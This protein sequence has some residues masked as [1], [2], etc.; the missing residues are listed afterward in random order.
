MAAAGWP[1]PPLVMRALPR[2]LWAWGRSGLRVMA[3]SEG[4]DG[5]VGFAGGS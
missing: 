3:S 4:G 1:A 5:G 2:L